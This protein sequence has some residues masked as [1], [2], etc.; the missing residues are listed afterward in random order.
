MLK[1]LL[2]SVLSCL[3]FACGAAFAAVEINTAD[4]A[5]LDSVAGIGP[6]TSKAILDARK[7]SGNFKDWADLQARVKGIGDKNSVKLSAAGLLVNG[8]SH[9]AAM[10]AAKPGKAEKPAKPEVK[11]EIKPIKAEPV[12][13]SDAKPK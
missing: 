8:Q 1:K 4:Q 10:T 6:A 5:A 7:K 9:Q 12:K 11:P 2:L 3:Y 13:A